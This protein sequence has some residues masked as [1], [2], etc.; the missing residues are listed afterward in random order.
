MSGPLTTMMGANARALGLALSDIPYKTVS[1]GSLPSGM[2]CTSS[3][4]AFVAAVDP[5]STT[6]K[7]VTPIGAPLQAGATLQMGAQI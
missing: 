7:H 3:L 6:W 2:N 4:A 5:T 1:E